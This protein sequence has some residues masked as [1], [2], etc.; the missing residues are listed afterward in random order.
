MSGGGGYAVADL[1]SKPYPGSFYATADY[2]RGMQFGANYPDGLNYT[3]VLTGAEMRALD[4]K[5]DD[6]LPGKGTVVTYSPLLYNQFSFPAC[7]TGGDPATATYIVNDTVDCI[8]MF[9]K[10]WE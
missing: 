3:P 6:G 7:G 10:M 8:P 9:G 4:T 1:M 2:T 5:I